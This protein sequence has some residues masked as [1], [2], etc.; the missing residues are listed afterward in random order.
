MSNLLPDSMIY[1]MEGHKGQVTSVRL[2]VNGNYC[3]STGKDKTVQLWNHVKGKH[4]YTFQGGHIAEVLEA[5]LFDLF[6]YIFFIKKTYIN[7]LISK[8]VIMLMPRLLPV[9][10]IN[11]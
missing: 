1:K 11:L 2:N 9:V 4:I 7:V 8:L 3:C 6:F 10:A 5:T